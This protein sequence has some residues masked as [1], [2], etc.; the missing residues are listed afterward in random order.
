MGAL[1]LISFPETPDGSFILIDFINLSQGVLPMPQYT[2]NACL[3]AAAL[4]ASASPA[5]AKDTRDVV[6][7]EDSAVVANTFGNCVRTKWS[8]GSDVCAPDKP[9][10]VAAPAPAPAP[11]KVI[12]KEER[13]VYF[14]FNKASLTSEA[15]TKL[16]TL[17]T[18]IKADTQVRGARVV[19]FADRMGSTSYNEQLSKKRAQNVLSYLTQRGVVNA[20]V[21]ET[22]WLGESEP[23]T[24][25][26]ESL[27]REELISCLQTDRRV[28]VEI[29][30]LSSAPAR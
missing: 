5:F 29:D 16:D 20:S 12:A 28:E 1:G 2:G 11:R 13:T 18:N 14:E 24:N 7:N 3:I 30:Y 17:A 6:R 22:R 19:G 26:P 10:P 25:C 23:K 27:K 21:A 15:Q 8:E 4:L 9:A